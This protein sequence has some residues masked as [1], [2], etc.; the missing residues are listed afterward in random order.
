MHRRRPIPDLGLALAVLVLSAC[1][2]GTRAGVSHARSATPLPVCRTQ[3]LHLATSFY[4]EAGGQ[5]IQT[6]TF[7][8][9][10][11]SACQMRGWPTLRV[12][13]KSGRAVPVRSRRVV[14]GAPTAPPFKIVVLF[15]YGAASFD[16]YGADWN[17][18][19]NRSCSHTTAILVTPPG[20]GEKLSTA[21]KMPKCGLF[22]V[23]PVIAGKSDREAWS[24]VWHK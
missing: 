18:L 22:D 19:A 16:V 9:R 8:N 13:D 1:S 15:P 12:R 20:A 24:V 21:V 14:Q 11:H 4:G 23:A 2:G 17:A 5:F 10:G 6:F 3:Q 7:T